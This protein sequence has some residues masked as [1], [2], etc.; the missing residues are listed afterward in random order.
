MHS[1]NIK[2]HTINHTAK[3]DDYSDLTNSCKVNMDGNKCFL[4]I[5]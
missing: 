2:V 4:Y 3:E 1:L 5:W